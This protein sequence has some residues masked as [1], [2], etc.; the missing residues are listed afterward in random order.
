MRSVDFVYT[1]VWV[2]MGSLRIGLGRAR[3][4]C[5]EPYQ[6]TLD[7]LRRSGNPKVRF[8]H[9]LPAFHNRETRMGEDIFQKT[10]AG[11]ARGD[12][13]SV[14]VRAVDSL[15]SV[16]EPDAHDQGRDGRHAGRLAPTCSGAPRRIGRASDLAGTES[17]SARRARRE[18]P[19]TPHGIGPG[20]RRFRP[21]SDH[22]RPVCL[23]LARSVGCANL[24]GKRDSP[25]AVH[26]L[27]SPVARLPPAAVLHRL[28]PDDRL[29]DHAAA[30]ADAAHRR[31]GRASGLSR[32]AKAC[33]RTAS[34]DDTRRGDGV[35]RPDR[36]GL[37]SQTGHGPG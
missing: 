27:A 15:R 14:R 21:E 10:G 22:R 33:W 37:S 1:D 8:M 26:A 4:D 31:A 19:R 30:R 6:V 5:S 34:S 7:V 29:A 17:V 35:L 12:G 9:C 23:G 28:A 2:S 24:R 25:V 36:A 3:P 32:E 20:V 13:R 18:D 16:G 11:W